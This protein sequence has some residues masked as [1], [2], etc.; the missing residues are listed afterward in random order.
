MFSRENP[1]SP[2]SNCSEWVGPVAVSAAAMSSG[3]RPVNSD[4]SLRLGSLPSF[5]SSSFLAHFIFC[6]CSF[7]PLLTFIVP[8]SLQNL[9][10]S[11]EIFGTA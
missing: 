8:S 4:S 3:L 11:P 7:I 9:L 2:L 6:A 10:I 1:S 5:C